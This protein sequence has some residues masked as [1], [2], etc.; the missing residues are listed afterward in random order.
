M[1]PGGAAPDA[2]VCAGGIA[3]KLIDRIREGGVLSAFLNHRSRFTTVIQQFP[4]F[5]ILNDG[6]GMK[7]TTEFA[8][9]LAK[10]LRK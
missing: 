4:L 5:V 6:V 1:R 8:I 3:P 9:S 7:G 10:D 2:A